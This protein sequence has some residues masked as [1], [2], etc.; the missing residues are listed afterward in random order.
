[1]RESRTAPV[2]KD[3][4]GARGVFHEG[5]VQ[6]L[7]EKFAVW[8]EERLPGARAF[9]STYDRYLIL[10]FYFCPQPNHSSAL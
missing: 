3:L 5:R 1:M 7:V 8:R 10:E 9:Q 2:E 6:E 4:M